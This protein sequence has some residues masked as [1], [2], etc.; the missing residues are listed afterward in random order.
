M[1]QKSV[2]LSLVTLVVLVFSTNIYTMESQLSKNNFNQNESLV[3]NMEEE[4]KTPL[5]DSIQG[6]RQND[7]LTLINN[8]NSG[9]ITKI[10]T[11]KFTIKIKSKKSRVKSFCKSVIP[12]LLCLNVMALGILVSGPFW[13]VNLVENACPTINNIVV[14]GETLNPLL[15]AV[16]KYGPLLQD[17]LDTCPQG[18]KFIG[19]TVAPQVA[20]FM[21]RFFNICNCTFPST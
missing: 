19:K 15:A 2:K 12:P 20:A 4:V 5:I 7:L 13:A 21:L 18:K 11:K 8:F 9:N 16:A 1:N 17:V 6:D 3:V 10:E 14:A